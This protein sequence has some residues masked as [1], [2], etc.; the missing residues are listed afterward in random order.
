MIDLTPSVLFILATHSHSTEEAIVRAVN[1]TKDNDT[2]GAIVGAAV[3]A[4]HGSQSI[5]YRWVEKLTGRTGKSNDGEV[6][7]RILHAKHAFWFET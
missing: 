1:D 6:F 7:K 3:G 2:V 4:L 5:P